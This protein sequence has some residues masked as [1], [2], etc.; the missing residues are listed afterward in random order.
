MRRLYI[1]LPPGKTDGW[2]MT[3]SEKVDGLNDDAI[4]MIEVITPRDHKRLTDLSQYSS[5]DITTMFNNVI[6]NMKA[7]I[8]AEYPQCTIEQKFA[9]LDSLFLQATSSGKP[10]LTKAYLE[11]N[12]EVDFVKLSTHLALQKELDD[13]NVLI[14]KLVQD[15]KDLGT[16]TLPIEL[17]LRDW[18]PK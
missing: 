5:E 6:N 12:N 2:A 1:E 14:S 15:I 4:E 10:E 8:E 7:S 3:Y 16:S 11:N 13:A 9:L 17:V 18:K